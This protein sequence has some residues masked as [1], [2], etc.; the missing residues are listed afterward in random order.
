MIDGETRTAFSMVRH[1]RDHSVI[2]VS[3]FILFTLYT[4]LNRIGILPEIYSDQYPQEYFRL[5]EKASTGQEKAENGKYRHELFKQ[6][7]ELFIEHRKG[8]PK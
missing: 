3:L 4:G 7:Y 2:I 1:L 6:E 5:V 8:D